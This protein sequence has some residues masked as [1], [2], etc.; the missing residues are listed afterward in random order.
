MFDNPGMLLAYC[1]F[2]FFADLE[3]KG[4]IVKKILN[5]FKVVGI[6]ASAIWSVIC[7][8][9]EVASIPWAEWAENGVLEHIKGL[10]EGI[11]LFPCCLFLMWILHRL[12]MFAFH[13]K[14]PEIFD[15]YG[16][17]RK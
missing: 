8:V 3:V 15:E 11:I 16:H 14:W 12:V 2:M 4:N 7:I 17:M 10:A 13:K 5:V 1:Y 6:I 9:K